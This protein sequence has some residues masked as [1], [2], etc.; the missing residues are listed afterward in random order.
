[1]PE[2]NCS[3]D[4]TPQHGKRVGRIYGIECSGPRHVTG[5]LVSLENLRWSP[6]QDG[7]LAYAQRIGRSSKHGLDCSKS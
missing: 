6:I 2:G 5:H 7:G 3:Y 4:L 1:M